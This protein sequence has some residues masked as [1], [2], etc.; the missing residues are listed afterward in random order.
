MAE[1]LGLALSQRQGRGGADLRAWSLQDLQA[2]FEKSAAWYHGVARGIDLR[3]VNPS[4]ERKSCGSETTFEED[5]VEPAAIEAGVLA[6]ADDVWAWYEKTGQR[7]RTVTVKIKWADFQQSSCS[8]SFPRAMDS[9]QTLHDV[10]LG[11]VRSVFPPPKGIPLVGVT[12]SNFAASADRLGTS[13]PLLTESDS[14]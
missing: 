3:P 14:A 8:Q 1:G 10:T 11:L 7:G 13:G 6:M 9:R 4:R 2:R 12:L 5:L